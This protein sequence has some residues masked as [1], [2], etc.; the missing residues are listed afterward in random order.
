MGQPTPIERVGG[1]SRVELYRG[2]SGHVTRFPRYNRPQVLLETRR[3]RCGEWANCFT[4]CCNAVGL[5]ARWVSSRHLP[6]IFASSPHA[7]P[8]SSHDFP[9]S[10]QVL[11]VTD[12][13]WTEVW[14]P[15]WG[16][17]VHCDPCENVLDAPLMYERGWGKH[18]SYVFAFT[19]HEA[20]DVAPRY[21]ADWVRTLAR[22]EW[23]GEGWLELTLASA[24]ASM[25]QALPPA[26]R[27]ALGNRA[28]AEA[29]QLAEL[30]R[31]LAER[32]AS[33]AAKAEA[34]AAN[35]GVTVAADKHAEARGRQTGSLEWRTARGEI[36]K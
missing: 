7:L 10:S 24:N 15:S 36:G 16:R 33:A 19:A 25:Q 9:M 14:L 11:D 20:T 28:A 34:E 29:E 21:A 30:R 35:S 5:E 12:H 23:V 6:V 31:P 17:W 13:V 32:E 18:L 2:P 26:T 22:R 3:G 27:A 4:L 8:V 1:A